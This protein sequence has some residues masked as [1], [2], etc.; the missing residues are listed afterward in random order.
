[1]GKICY[2]FIYNRDKHLNSDGKALVQ[3]EA[4]QSGRRVYFSTHIYLTPKQW[5]AK[6]GLVV[7]HPEADSPIM[8]KASNKQMK[9]LYKVN[10]KECKNVKL[11]SNSYAFVHG[12]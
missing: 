5:S 7:H 8:V 12:Y 1:M 10:M 2:R 3:I 9:L 4:Y 11:S 6:K